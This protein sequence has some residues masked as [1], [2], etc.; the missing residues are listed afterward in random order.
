MSRAIALGSDVVRLVRRD[1]RFQAAKVGRIPEPNWRSNGECL[2]HDP[3]LF[4]PNA[5]E[6]PSPAIAICSICPV[7]APCLAASLDSAE[8]DGVWGG[9]TP[10]ERRAMRR[11][12]AISG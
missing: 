11:V 6:D 3:E 4:F 1:P 9:T 7:Q 8:C 5:A 12:W 10:G 2:K